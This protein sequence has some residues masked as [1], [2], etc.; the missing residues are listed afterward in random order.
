[1]GVVPS[2]SALEHETARGSGSRMLPMQDCSNSNLNF[3][4]FKRL[5]RYL[6]LTRTDLIH[7]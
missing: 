1:M 5:K 3:K 7:F 6:H 2:G 4:V